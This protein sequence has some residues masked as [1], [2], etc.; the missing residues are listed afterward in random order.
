MTTTTA[1]VQIREFRALGTYV[2]LQTEGD[3]DRAHHRAA[4]VLAA[5]DLACSRFRADSDLTRVN[6]AAGSWVPVDDLL[7]RAVEVAVAVAD[8]TDGLVDPCL[9]RTLVELGYDTDF[10]QLRTL[11]TARTSATVVP[12]AW[13][14][15]ELDPAGAIR[16]PAEVALDLGATAK[17]WASDLVALTLVEEFGAPVLVSLGGDLRVATPPGHH[18]TWTVRIT[19]YPDGR[20][21]EIA[22]ETVALDSGG[23]ATSS[24][25]VRRWRT[26]SAEVHH[27]VDPRTGRPT[28]GPWRTATATGP[29]ATAANAAS[30]AALV[31]GAAAPAWLSARRIDARLVGTAGQVRT[32]GA[33]PD[34]STDSTDHTD[35]TDS[36]DHQEDPCSRP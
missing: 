11:D 6:R 8:E 27:L 30:T 33:W 2:H 25:R 18:R 19:E 22:P 31:L 28:D 17:A 23:L 20:G 16:I 35:S 1:P 7:L 13:R 36:T 12:G 15:I 9:G 21:D 24:T 10:G 4:E 3:P 5:I 29:S 14:R 26:G 34:A 32:C